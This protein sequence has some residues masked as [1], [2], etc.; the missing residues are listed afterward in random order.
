MY[1]RIVEWR[2]ELSPL[3]ARPMPESERVANIMEIQFELEK[4]GIPSPADPYDMN[5]WH[6]FLMR[7]APLSRHWE[8]GKARDL[9]VEE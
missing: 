1:D 2:Q 8:V 6:Q 7:L 4:L 5:K 9:L 3:T